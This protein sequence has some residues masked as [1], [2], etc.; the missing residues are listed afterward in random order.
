LGYRSAIE[1]ALISSK[2]AQFPSPSPEPEIFPSISS[3]NEAIEIKIDDISEEIIDQYANIITNSSKAEVKDVAWKYIGK[4]AENKRIWKYAAVWKLLDSELLATTPTVFFRHA[5]TILRWMLRNSKSELTGNN[6]TPNK[7]RDHYLP[8]FKEILGS[9]NNAWNSYDRVY[10]LEIL[11]DITDTCERCDILWEAWKKCAQGI[12][13]DD[14]YT[15]LTQF[16]STELEN[17]SEKCKDFIRMELINI[18]ENGQP[19]YFAEG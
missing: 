12:K 16:I 11:K 5:L 19:P 1:S 4:L 7:V 2:N 15:H 6:S 3:P 17:S 14:K 9:N 8:K 18:I 13:G 10:V